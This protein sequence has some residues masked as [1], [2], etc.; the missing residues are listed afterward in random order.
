[1]PVNLDNL[2][3]KELQTIIADANAKMKNAHS[4][5]IQDVRKKIDHLLSNSGLTLAEVYPTR[6][7]KKATGKKGSVAPKYRDL[8][9]P[10]KTWSGRGKRP[11]WFIQAIKKRGVTPENLLIDGV[12]KAPAKT[13]KTATKK[14]VKK[15]VKK[16]ATKKPAKA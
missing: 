16:T 9:D 7:G 8:V 4:N 6:G 2:S 13:A 5:L 3:P 10:T 15:A 12:A 11:L 14:A 1:M